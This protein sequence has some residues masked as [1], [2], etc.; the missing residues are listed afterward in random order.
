MQT[1]KWT[2]MESE[3]NIKLSVIVYYTL[4]GSMCDDNGDV[5]SDIVADTDSFCGIV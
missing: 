2:E 1:W 3:H 4:S 5:V